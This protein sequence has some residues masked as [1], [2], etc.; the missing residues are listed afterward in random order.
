M[1]REDIANGNLKKIR[2]NAQRLQD[3][4]EQKSLSHYIATKAKE[5]D[6]DGLK[7]L[8]GKGESSC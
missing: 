1:F 8:F 4:S 5:Y 7:Q 3:S 6:L 2:E